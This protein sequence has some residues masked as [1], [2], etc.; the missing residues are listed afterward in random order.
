MR[1]SLLF[2][3]HSSLLQR[4]AKCVLQSVFKK[5]FL[6]L[7]FVTCKYWKLL[8]RVLKAHD[9]LILCVICFVYY[10]LK[11]F[12]H[13]YF[14]KINFAQLNHVYFLLFTYGP[15]QTTQNTTQTVSYCLQYHLA[16]VSS[17]LT[18]LSVIRTKVVLHNVLEFLD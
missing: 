13:K 9:S 6:R 10:H 14:I 12:L 11:G 8:F 2:L 18:I 4:D 7:T 15:N 17:F 3:H 1:N 5:R 16:R